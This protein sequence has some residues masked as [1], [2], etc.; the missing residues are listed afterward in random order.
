[1][2]FPTLIVTILKLI[3]YIVLYIVIGFGPGFIGG[4]LLAN[5]IFGKNKPLRMDNHQKSI[6]KATEHNKQWH[7]DQPKWQ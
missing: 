2:D 1:M 7:P 5:T 3:V 6:L 4:V